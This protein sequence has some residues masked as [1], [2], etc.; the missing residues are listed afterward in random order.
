MKLKIVIVLVLIIS[1]PQF[2]ISQSIDYNTIG[3]GARARGMGG[4]FIGVAD[5][6]TAASWNP[7]G[8]ARLDAAEASVVGMF[9][10]YTPSTDVP[11]FDADPYKHSHFGLNFASVA[12]P[13][14]LGDRNMVAAVAYQKVTDAYDKYD[15]EEEMVEQTGGLNAITPS[16]GIQLTSSVFLGASVNIITGKEEYAYEDKTGWDANYDYTTD[17]SGI[18]FTVGGL[19]DFNQFKLGVVFKS[20][21][22]LTIENEDRLWD[23]KF[24]MPQ[25]LGFGA[26]FAAT[27]NLTI[28]ADYEMRK[29]SEAEWEDSETEETYD[30]ELLDINQF[31]F[32]AEY[33]LMTGENILPIRLGFATTPLPVEDDNGDQVVGRNI[34]AGIGIIMGNI[35][36]DLGVEY[37]FYSYEFDTGYETYEYADNY[38]RFIMSG[39]FHFGQ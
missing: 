9:E 23:Y 25:M 24:S 7:A 29:Y 17:M 11:D 35:N 18:N 33:L 14:S 6:A 31:R 4:A 34:T 10:S 12:I 3:A 5:D 16:L 26:A 19:F 27:E 32:G 22:S 28:A 38:L 13:L 37:N 2:V 21:Y 30:P 8:L 39:V 36:F 15:T 1:L 20:P